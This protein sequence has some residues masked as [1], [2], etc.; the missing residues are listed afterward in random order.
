MRKH[1]SALQNKISLIV[2]H[3]PFNIIITDLYFNRTNA[4]TRRISRLLNT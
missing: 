4:H 3:I 2:L 1:K